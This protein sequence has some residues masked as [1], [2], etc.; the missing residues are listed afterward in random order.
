MF[1]SH[2][3]THISLAVRDLERTVRF[4]V[5]VFGVREYFRDATS[6]QVLGPGPHDVIAFEQD[7]VA[8]GVRGGITHFGF[9][10]QS[11]GDID[12]AIAEVERAGGIILRRGAFSPG[13]PYVYVADPDGYEIEIWYE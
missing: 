10:L 7:P 3:L 2:G 9:R 5:Q 12:V 8:A 6:V 11:P 13:Y 4:Y 1:Q